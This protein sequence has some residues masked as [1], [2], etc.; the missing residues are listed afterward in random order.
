LLNL[1]LDQAEELETRGTI[2]DKAPPPPPADELIRLALEC[3]PDLVSYRLGIQY[4]QSDVRLA[5]AQRFQDVFL[6]YQ[7]YTFQ[8]NKPFDAQSTHSW[9]VGVTVP[10]PV[11]DRNQGRIQRAQ[12]NVQQTQ[13]ELATLEQQ[14]ATDVRQAERRYAISRES[15]SQIKSRLLPRAAQVRDNA[16]RRYQGGEGDI[17]DFL[18]AQREY[19]DVVRQYR[20]TLTR[21]R[22]SMLDLNT[23]VGQRILP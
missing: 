4:A 15:A 9:A 1:R 13:L 2:Q 10:L 12:I 3:R 17:V 11:F 16:L 18:N 6:L 22:R 14:V 19:N 20:D 8:N 7:P 21:H 23:V 5:K